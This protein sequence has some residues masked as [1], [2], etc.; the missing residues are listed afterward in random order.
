MKTSNF[1]IF[2][3]A[4][5]IS[6]A[7]SSPR[8]IASGFRVYRAL[9]PGTFFKMVDWAEYV[10]LY[11]QQLNSLDPHRVW[12]ELHQLAAG[13]EPVLLCWEKPGENCHRRLVAEWFERMLGYEVPE[14]NP[15][16]IEGRR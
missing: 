13:A 11:R 4:G 14:L 7:R 12:D 15:G 10:S 3:G 1:F 9:A 2:G 8:N 5:R 16:S 6:I